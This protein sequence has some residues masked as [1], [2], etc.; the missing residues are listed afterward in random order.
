MKAWREE[1]V[2]NW[3]L[4]IQNLK[5]LQK[6]ASKE[7]Y[8]KQKLTIDMMATCPEAYKLCLNKSLN[9][10]FI[11]RYL[12]DFSN[13]YYEIL[14][15][16]LE[17]SN[18]NGAQN[19]HMWI[20]S[21]L[22]LQQSYASYTNFEALASINAVMAK[23]ADYL[24]KNIQGASSNEVISWLLNLILLIDVFKQTFLKKHLII[25]RAYGLI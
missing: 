21:L 17:G 15:N 16:K 8:I 9:L 23:E 22:A 5:Y 24:Q 7:Q 18:Q 11:E 2:G 4:V 25:A 6:T 12:I 19:F 3:K 20:Y 10:S 1:S 14:S 13:S